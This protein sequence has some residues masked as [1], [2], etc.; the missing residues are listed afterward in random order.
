MVV[1]FV[2]W[3]RV[4]VEPQEVHLQDEDEEEDVGEGEEP[5]IWIWIWTQTFIDSS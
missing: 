2:Q 1:V 5:R 4:A 3:T